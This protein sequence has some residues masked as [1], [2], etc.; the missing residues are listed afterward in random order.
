MVSVDLVQQQW[1][2]SA[3]S[4]AWQVLV[5]GAWTPCIMGVLPL[6][7][8]LLLGVL[9]VLCPSRIQAGV[10]PP[11]LPVHVLLQGQVCAC[12]TAGRMHVCQQRCCRLATFQQ[13]QQR[14]GWLLDTAVKGFTTRWVDAVDVVCV[15]VCNFWVCL[16]QCC[17]PGGGGAGCWA[18]Q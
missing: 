12:I 14:M 11:N 9:V 4:A 7:Q 1:A 2:A 16:S 17:V 3:A 6:L 5:V 13:G 18:Q 8:L 15:C 10:V